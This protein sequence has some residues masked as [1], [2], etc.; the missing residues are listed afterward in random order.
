MRSK[1]NPTAIEYMS[2]ETILN[3]ENF[4]KKFPD[5]KHDAYLLLTFD[6]NDINIIEN[7]YSKVANL[8]L[9]QGAIDAYFID[10]DERKSVWSARGAFLEAIK[11]STDKMDECDVVVPKD[12]I[13]LIISNIL[14]SYQNN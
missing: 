8:C 14:I 6:G 12:L 3:S 5:S 7:D 10:T 2:K 9:V 11:A 13:L 4:R 1:T